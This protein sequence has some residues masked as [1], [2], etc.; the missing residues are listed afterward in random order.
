MIIA[1]K[2]PLDCYYKVIDF[3]FGSPKQLYDNVLKEI[4]NLSQE[5][6]R[7]KYISNIIISLGTSVTLG[8]IN[9]NNLWFRLI[10]KKYFI[11]QIALKMR[12]QNLPLFSLHKIFINFECLSK[13]E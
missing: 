6:N 5:F 8:N 10:Y 12:N 1:Q 7:K 2:M 11:N 9:W 4:N 3:V 13:L